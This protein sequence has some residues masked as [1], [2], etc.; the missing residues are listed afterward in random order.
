MRK[1]TWHI[2]IGVLTVILLVGLVFIALL[3]KIGQEPSGEVPTVTGGQQANGNENEERDYPESGGETMGTGN[4]TQGL[5]KPTEGKT[6]ESE[7]KLP[8][9][10]PE[11]EPVKETTPP[12]ATES[13]K[14]QGGYETPRD[15]S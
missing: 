10:D 1:K 14:Q 15:Y 11:K 2:L 6:P 4:E 7:N 3:P 8:E 13:G 5:Q 12:S 9:K